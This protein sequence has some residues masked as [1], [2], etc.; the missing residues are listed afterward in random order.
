MENVKELSRNNGI[1]KKAKEG[2]YGGE[3]REL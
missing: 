1:G 2:K 3:R